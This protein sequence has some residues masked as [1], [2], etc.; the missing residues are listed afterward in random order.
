MTPGRMTSDPKHW[1]VMQLIS[2][3]AVVDMEG[4]APQ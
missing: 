4:P 1:F 3:S 2:E